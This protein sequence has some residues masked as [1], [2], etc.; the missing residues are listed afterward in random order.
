MGFCHPSLC[1]PLRRWQEDSHWRDDGQKRSSETA[2][3]A[4][5]RAA[6]KS[7]GIQI[8]DPTE[9]LCLRQTCWAIIFLLHSGNCYFQSAHFNQ[10]NHWTKA[11]TE[12]PL[13]QMHFFYLLKWFHVIS[14]KESDVALCWNYTFTCLLI[15][16]I[17]LMLQPHRCWYKFTSGELRR[18]CVLLQDTSE[19]RGL[20]V[21]LAEMKNEF[22]EMCRCTVD[23]V[24]HETKSPDF[25][26][27]RNNHSLGQKEVKISGSSIQ[28]WH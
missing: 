1:R 8:D 19:G 15:K 10:N 23:C 5:R 6:V 3:T 25:T 18:L 7:A 9:S 16:E 13:Q 11:R 17:C 4:D 12:R 21:P 22:C 2:E 20:R 26:F 14:K 28:A 24:R 27:T